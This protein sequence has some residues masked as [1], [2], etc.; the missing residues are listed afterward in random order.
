MPCETP[1]DCPYM[2]CMIALCQEF[3][4]SYQQAANGTSCDDGQAYVTSNEILLE[5]VSLLSTLIHFCR[6]NGVDWCNG[7]SGC[8]HAGSPCTNT[9]CKTFC[10]EKGEGNYLC[11]D[12]GK[13]LYCIF[14]TSVDN[15]MCDDGNWCN[16]I[17]FFDCILTIL[18]R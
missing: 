9:P 10:N 12:P 16:G 13:L 15:M 11:Q 4:C 6:C 14:L 18:S 2:I 3:Q 7:V 5:I 1:D 17:L 8:M